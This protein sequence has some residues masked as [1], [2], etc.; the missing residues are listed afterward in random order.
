MKFKE[1]QG[2]LRATLQ[3]AKRHHSRLWGR[4]KFIHAG[5]APLRFRK[6]IY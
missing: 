1:K 2:D 6:K 4:F 5:Y 3:Q